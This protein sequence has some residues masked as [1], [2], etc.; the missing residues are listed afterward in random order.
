MDISLRRGVIGLLVGLVSSITLAATLDQPGLAVALGGLVGIGYALSFRPASRAYADSAM[1]AA[2]LGVPLWCVVNIIALPVFASQLPQWTPEGMLARFPALVG[3]V[4]FGVG[5]GLLRQAFSDLIDWRLGPEPMPPAP[6]RVVSTRVVILGGGFAGVT[7]AQHL[8]QQFGADPTVAFT[9]VSDTNA[10]LF[11]PMLAEVAASSL[12]PTH[13]S[14]PLRTSLRRTDVVRGRVE[15][16][17]LDQR[18]VI[19][20]A[21]ERAPARTIRFDHL[22]LALGSVSNYLGMRQVQELSFDFKSL[23]DAMRIRNHVIDMF[24][25]ADREPDPVTRQALLTFVVAGGGFAG[26][27]LAGGLN[28]FA[29]GMLAYYPNVPPQELRIILVHARERIL[30]ELSAPLA[31]YA[32]QRMAARGVAFKLNTRVA[33]ARPGVAVLQPA[34]EIRTETLVWTAGTTPNPLVTTL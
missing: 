30:P 17:D 9:L 22:V 15:Q 12:E 18:R 21:D 25:R 24:E 13:I 5:L 26:A 29:R 31:E 4:L 23:A 1:T 27:E 16:I 11:T 14:T 10:L 3:W 19:L 20:A 34:E 28:D 2:A 6:A 33:G 7:T 32:R 8:E